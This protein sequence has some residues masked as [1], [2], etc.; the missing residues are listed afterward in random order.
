MESIIKVSDLGRDYKIAKRSGNIA[1][2]LFSREYETVNAVKDVNFEIKR[3]EYVGFVGPNGAG[4]S[5]TIKMLVGILVPS[6][7][8]VSVIGNDPFKMRKHNANHI[9]VVFG[10]RSQLWWDLPI[11][12]TFVLLKKMY[13]VSDEIYNKNISLYKDHL[14]L[15]EIWNQPVRQLS[16]GQ[17]MR[18]EIA[19]SMLHN[20]QVLFLDEP[21]IGLDI[22][23]KHNIRE[24]ISYVGKEYGTTVILT[25]HDMKDIEEVCE[26]IILI[27]NG[28][29]VID[30]KMDELKKRYNRSALI[31]VSFVKPVKAISIDGIKGEMQ[32][33]GLEWEFILDK[34]I[35][36]TGHL[37]SELSKLEELADVE[38]KE[39]AVEDI[40]HDIYL[41]G[42]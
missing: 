15:D 12:D 10:Q 5:T 23:A 4:K 11:G 3:G 19:A 26:R 2:F 29:I 27:D 7:G 6:A 16:L 31:K 25:S 13:K 34:S 30:T 22:V 20:P 1:K 8:A 32:S 24:F 41:S 40:I 39:Q 36:S 38:I 35:M 28:T 33:N 14:K 37:I 17:R 18:A 21:T 42:I 9:G